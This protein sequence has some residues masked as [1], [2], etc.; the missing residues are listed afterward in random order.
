MVW[1]YQPERCEAYRVS[2]RCA[3]KCEFYMPSVAVNPC[4]TRKR[5]QRTNGGHLLED[6]LI[7]SIVSCE[8]KYLRLILVVKG[9]RFSLV[10]G[11]KI[12]WKPQKNNMLD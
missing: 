11:K 3:K 9:V 12:D 10:S 7:Q 8:R 2:L 4:L 6:S 1:H 5:E